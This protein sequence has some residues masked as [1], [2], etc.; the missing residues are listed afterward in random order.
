MM[1]GI[2]FLAWSTIMRLPLFGNGGYLSLII[3]F[4]GTPLIGSLIVWP[5]GGVFSAV[6]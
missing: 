3:I 6:F 2:A 1:G 5:S 4:I